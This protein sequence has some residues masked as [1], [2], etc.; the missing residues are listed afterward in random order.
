MTGRKVLV[1]QYDF[2]TISEL[3]RE[4]GRQV[5]EFRIRK[6]MEQLKVAELA[7]ISDRAVR[8]LEQG[9]GS[10]INTLLRVMKALGALDG[11]NNLF[12]QAPTVDPIALLNRPKPRVR[13]VLKRR[14]GPHE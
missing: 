4:L 9:R 10:S 7:G 12:P 8:G 14:E 6:E 1:V 2:L 5:R 11:L 3:E 13:I